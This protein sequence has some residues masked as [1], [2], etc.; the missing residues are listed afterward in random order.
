M[1][2]KKKINKYTIF[3]SLVIGVLLFQSIFIYSFIIIESEENVEKQKLK[4]SDFWVLPYR[5]HIDNNWSDTASAY[6]WCSGLGTPQTPYKIENVTID[7]QNS[8]SCIYILNTNDHF[9]IQNCTLINSEAS[10][11]GA[12][13]L[14]F[15]SN[16]KII[17]NNITKNNGRAV[18]LYVGNNIL[19]EDNNIVNNGYG[20]TLSYSNGNEIIKNDIQDSNLYGIYLYDADN[21]VVMENEVVHNGYYAGGYHGIYITESS[22]PTDCLNNTVKHNNVQNNRKSGIYIN[23]CDNNTIFGNSVENNLEYGIYFY[24]SDDIII[25]GNKIN[26]NGYGCIANQSSVNY[27]DEWNVCNDVIDPFTIDETGGGD[28]TWAQVSQFAWVDGSGSYSDPYMLADLSIDAQSSGSCIV[29]DTSFNKH[30]VISGCTV[31][32]GQASGGNAGIRLNDVQDGTITLN[33]IMNNYIGIY[34]DHAENVTVSDNDLYDNLGQGIILYQSPQNYILDNDQYGSIYYG[35]LVNTFSNNNTIKGNVFR[36][37]TGATGHGDG[38]RVLDSDDNRFIDNTLINNDRGIKIE[39]DS[40]NNTITQNTIQNNTDYGALV[41][42]NTRVCRDNLFYLNDFNNPLG[43]NAYDNG[44]D[45]NWDNGAT[46]NIWN[47]YSG[48]DANDDGFGDTPYVL[49]GIGGGQDNLPIFDDG[50][51]I[52][53]VVTILAPIDNSRYNIT[54]PSYQISIVEDNLDSYWYIISWD[55]GESP[56]FTAS[57][58]GTVDQALWDSLPLGNYTLTVYANDTAGNIGSDSVTIIIEGLPSGSPAIP[59]GSFYLIISLVSVAIILIS[60][61]YKLRK[62][63]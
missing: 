52:A 32:N 51:S 25:I 23:S 63:F 33:T 9:I 26:D 3:L 53:P 39:D 50:D 18:S 34:L 35:L 31:V 27:K 6:D 47:D 21:N 49:P 57:L 10:P 28:F 8:G 48:V 56:A 54:A 7:A 5:I 29:I 17:D 22:A 11:H 30:F 20:V 62:K 19:V 40:H 44:T 60:I 38:I 46:G 55:S 61:N 59:F 58:S 13:R 14:Y 43:L 37:N 4:N 16:G 1:K 42:A 2:F 15:V 24:D 41:I 12:I 36:N 45:T